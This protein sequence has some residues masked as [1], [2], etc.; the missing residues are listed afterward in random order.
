M[1]EY[2]DR[3]HRTLVSHRLHSFEHDYFHTELTLSTEIFF[4]HELHESPSPS[5]HTKNDKND[6][7][8]YDF[9]VPKF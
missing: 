7:D 6:T 1:L 3:Y 2:F 5:H 8:F 4:E 9:W